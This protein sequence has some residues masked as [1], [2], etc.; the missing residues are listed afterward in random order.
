MIE[1]GKATGNRIIMPVGRYAGKVVDSLP[2]SYL[3]WIITQDFSEEIMEIA[4]N[5]IKDSS[6]NS[7]HIAISR[8][9]YDQYS[10]R[11]IDR[12]KIH[13][14]GF[15]TFVVQEAERAWEQGVDVSKHRHKDDGVLKELE[16]IVW[17]FRV[18]PQFPEYKEVITCYP[19]LTP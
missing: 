5:K 10:M 19:L 16:G 9:T 2:N 8:H 11:F 17:V 13:T 1:T 12:W 15:G 18:S 7:D 14:T 4:R 3:R 6:Y